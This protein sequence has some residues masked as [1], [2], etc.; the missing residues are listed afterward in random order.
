[1]ILEN[2]LK[3]FNP[4]L[5]REDLTIVRSFKELLDREDKQEKFIKELDKKIVNK[6]IELK[7]KIEVSEIKVNTALFGNKKFI[8]ESYAYE[9]PLTRDYFEDSSLVNFKDNVLTNNAIKSSKS[10]T[11]D[12]TIANIISR[13]STNFKFVSK[14]LFIEKN[15]YNNF[16]ELEVLIPKDIKSGVLT[17]GFNKFDN[18]S[19]LDTHGK[20]VI[21]K[22]IT[23][24]ISY[25][26]NGKTN[27]VII[28]F[29]RNVNKELMLTD[30]YISEDTF[31]LK[32]TVTTKPI[33]I[34]QTLSQIGINTCDNYSEDYTELDYELS[35]N[36]GPYRR[37]R[38]L[39]KQ[40]NI[41]LNSILSVDDS[42]SFYRLQEY[43]VQ[44]KKQYFPVVGIRNP[45]VH[46]IKAFNYK[47]GENLGII[48]KDT[49]VF[50]S[51]VETKILIN[52]D[53]EIVVNDIITVADKDNTEVTIPKG[54]SNIKLNN[55]LWNQQENL[56]KY[57][58]LEVNQDNLK[59]KDK[60]TKEILHKVIDFNPKVKEKNSVF[61]QLILKGQIFTEEVN[62]MLTRI[63]GL[64]YIEKTNDSD[65]F[66][67]VKNKELFVESVRLRITLESKEE[68]KPVFISSL[69]I[70]GI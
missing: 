32:S 22:T 10:S 57:E 53:D 55:T 47:L 5:T 64:I 8:D 61:L 65:L 43:V 21:P 58:I 35:I 67:Q 12:L 68:V 9:I 20:E 50:H 37:I 45:D 31:N 6:F 56:L 70:R 3:K 52:K 16:Q 2:V 38:P 60:L 11:R 59:L 19:I 69:T 26:V 66:I 51:P 1:M 15:Y 41:D 27:S 17:I 44:D 40:K 7:E 42:Y 46:L 4:N 48:L 62:K 49:F 54:Y 14:K 36:N 18:I 29:A 30:F 28:R 25:P 34:N 33:L 13:K 23:N 24:S 39:N 63:N